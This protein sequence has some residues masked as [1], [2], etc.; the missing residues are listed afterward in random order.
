MNHSGSCIK[1]YNKSSAIQLL[2]VRGIK[3][4]LTKNNKGYNH[5][6]K[7]SYNKLR[8]TYSSQKRLNSNEIDVFMYIDTCNITSIFNHTHKPHNRQSIYH[9]YMLR[10]IDIP[11][12]YY[13]DLML[14][15][16]N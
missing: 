16:Q 10:K 13:W 11:H 2:I 4:V 8:F 6:R 1:S 5:F 14:L 3:W 15:Y 12:I 9:L 7:Y